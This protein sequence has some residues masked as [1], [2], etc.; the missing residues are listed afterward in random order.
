MFFIF[1]KSK[2][3]NDLVIRAGEWDSQTENELLPLQ[4]GEVLKII[5]HEK[6]YGG[7]LFNDVALVIVKKPFLLRENVGTLCLPKP[8]YLF[9]KERCYASGWGK[10][11]FGKHGNYLIIYRCTTF[12]VVICEILLHLLPICLVI[13]YNCVEMLQNLPKMSTLVS[14]A[15]SELPT[16]STSRP[17]G[18]YYFP[19]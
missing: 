1:H 8:N 15:K 3:P 5:K 17:M 14:E 2:D 6:Y 19:R 9:D 7:A 11:V 12:R 10:N 13:E 18:V 4:D 16:S